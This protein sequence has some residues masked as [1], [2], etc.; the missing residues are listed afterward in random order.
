MNDGRVGGGAPSRPANVALIPVT[1]P[2]CAACPELIHQHMVL[3]AVHDIQPGAEARRGRRHGLRMRGA[4][5]RCGSY[6]KP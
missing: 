4:C 5:A 1:C 6:R 3:M 2:G